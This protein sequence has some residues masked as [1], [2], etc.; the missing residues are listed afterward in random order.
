MTQVS[1]AFQLPLIGMSPVSISYH[2]RIN[3]DT[4]VG[5][6]V[7][8]I[9]ISKSTVAVFPLDLPIGDVDCSLSTSDFW[10]LANIYGWL[11][12]TIA[13]LSLAHM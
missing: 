12:R 10:I 7:V 2:Q 6:L 11:G 4:L 5:V 13:M 9:S 1:C 8:L 3:I